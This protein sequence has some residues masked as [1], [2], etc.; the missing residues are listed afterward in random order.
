MME[1]G[2]EL[3]NKFEANLGAITV[4][5]QRVAKAFETDAAL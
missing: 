3:D 1:D 4:A 5:A 2:G